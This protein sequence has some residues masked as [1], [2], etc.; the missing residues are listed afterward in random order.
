LETVVKKYERYGPILDTVVWHLKEGR[1]RQ[2]AEVLNALPDEEVRSFLFFACRH[3][4]RDLDL[5][6]EQAR[7][8]TA[9]D[10]PSQ[11]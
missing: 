11:N 6:R 7:E 4:E 5:I 1:D 8:L 2:A 3:V 10:M 9:R